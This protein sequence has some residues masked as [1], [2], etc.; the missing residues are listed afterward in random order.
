MTFK[1]LDFNLD[2]IIESLVSAGM[3][4]RKSEMPLAKSKYFDDKGLEVPGF[5]P[6][7]GSEEEFSSL[8][9]KYENCSNAKWWQNNC[10]AANESFSFQNY[11]DMNA[12]SENPT[13][14]LCAA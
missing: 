8:I 4:V 13:E 3:I 7:D 9:G 2:D 12:F 14:C 1:D 11:G 6:F 10:S 5:P